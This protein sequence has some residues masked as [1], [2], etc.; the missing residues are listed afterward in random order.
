MIETT[1]QELFI[2]SRFVPLAARFFPANPMTHLR[3]PSLRGPQLCFQ[4]P[5]PNSRMISHK[6]ANYK[7]FGSYPG[8]G[9]RFTYVQIMGKSINLNLPLDLPGISD[10]PK[11]M[12]KSINGTFFLH[13]L[14]QNIWRKRRWR[15]R[16]RRPGSLGRCRTVPRWLLRRSRS[17]TWDTLW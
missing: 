4:F 9:Q 10:N 7:L 8:F 2:I 3:G 16:E 12:G 14:P 6:S 1:N 5:S 17:S 15:R 11:I 13:R